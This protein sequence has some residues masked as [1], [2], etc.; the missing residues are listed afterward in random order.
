MDRLDLS[1]AT[2]LA[3]GD[4]VEAEAFQDSGGNLA[5]LKIPD[6]SPEVSMTW[7][8]RGRNRGQRRSARSTG[9]SPF[10]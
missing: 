8:A 9:L 1:T 10:S 5:V 6:F 4:F 2:S 7:L 3:A